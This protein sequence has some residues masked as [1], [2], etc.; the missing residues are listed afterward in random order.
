[1][2][3]VEHDMA[4]IMRRCDRVQVLDYGHSICVGTPQEVQR[5]ERV[6]AAY[7]GTEGT[8]LVDE[9]PAPTITPA[10]NGHG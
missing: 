9:M 7:L 6:L 5:D 10:G 1:V 8:A 2:V 3:V 4:L